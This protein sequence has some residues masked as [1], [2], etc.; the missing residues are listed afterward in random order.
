MNQGLRLPIRVPILQL[1]CYKGFSCEFY[2][3]GVCLWIGTIELTFLKSAPDDSPH[4]EIQYQIMKFV[5]INE[6]EV[7]ISDFRIILKNSDESMDFTD[8]SPWNCFVFKCVQMVPHVNVL[9]WKSRNWQIWQIDDFGVWVW[10]NPWISLKS[11]P[12]TDPW[13]KVCPDGTPSGFWK[14]WGVSSET[15]TQIRETRTRISETRTPSNPL[16]N[17]SRIQAAHKGA[18]LAA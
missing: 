7:N 1:N 9:F 5:K 6:I 4:H 2:F 18:H 17:E 3:R 8:L 10:W 13:W 14:L 11:S 15:R 16:W 12:W